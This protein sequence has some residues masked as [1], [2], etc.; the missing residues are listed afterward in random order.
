MPA[1]NSLFSPEG[2]DDQLQLAQRRSQQG[3]HGNGAG[4]RGG[5]AAALAARKRQPFPHRERNTAFQMVAAARAVEH[6]AS[7]QC[8]RVTAWIA[9]QIAMSRVAKLNA[10]RSA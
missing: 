1:G 6:G 10:W 5:G 4:D 9:R 8:R 7:R 3:I 2:R